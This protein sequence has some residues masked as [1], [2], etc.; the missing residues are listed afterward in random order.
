MSAVC[1]IP[2]SAASDLAPS[3]FARAASSLLSRLAKPPLS[4]GKFVVWRGV[5][6]RAVEA[7]LV[8]VGD[9]VADDA[10]R[11]SNVGRCFVVE[12]LA[13]EYAVPAFALAVPLRV[14]GARAH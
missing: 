10:S 11:L 9:E 13:L 8:R 1:V 3:R 12:L 6:E 7:H 2:C 4:S 5:A 14:V